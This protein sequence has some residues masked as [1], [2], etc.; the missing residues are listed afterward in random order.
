MVVGVQ[1]PYQDNHPG[2]G[3]EEVW[4]HPIQDVLD[5]VE[6]PVGREVHVGVALGSTAM[7]K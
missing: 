6:V 1:V 5:G 2:R 7:V 4:V 3:K